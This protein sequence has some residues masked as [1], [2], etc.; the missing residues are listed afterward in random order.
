MTEKVA[1]TADPDA[2]QYDRYGRMRYHPDFHE[3]HKKPW[4]NQDERYLIENYAKD[5]PEAVSLALG[6]TI[7]VV[8]TRAYELRKAGRMPRRVPGA[9]THRRSGSA[10]A[11]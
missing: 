1:A 5:G 10:G 7:H 4:T 9:S 6:R 2:V 3:N 11:A 8:M